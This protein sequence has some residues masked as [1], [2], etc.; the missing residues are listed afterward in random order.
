[1]ASRWK[2]AFYGD[3]AELNWS[4]PGLVLRPRKKSLWHK[5]GWKKAA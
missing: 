4:A 2:Q 5:I 1:M 3:I